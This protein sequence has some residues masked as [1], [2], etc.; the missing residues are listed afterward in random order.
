MD[1]LDL[2]AAQGTLKS[3]LHH[4]SSKTSVLRYSAF[5]MIQLSHPHMTIGKTTALTIW[6]FVGRVMSLFF[7]ML[8]R[9]VI[10]FLPRSK[11]LVISWLQSPPRVIFGARK[12]NICTCFHCFP[13]IYLPGGDGTGCHDLG[14]LNIEFSAS[15]FTLVFHFHQEAL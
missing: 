7:N 5:F 4:H 12:S 14:F 2:L 9:F 10:A 13:I 6:T 15:F 8:S 3:L 11:H 1:W